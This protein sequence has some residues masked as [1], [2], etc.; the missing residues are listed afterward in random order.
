MSYDSDEV[1]GAETFQSVD[2]NMCRAA[3][4]GSDALP[5]SRVTPRLLCHGGLRLV[6]DLGMTP[7]GPRG[8]SR[9]DGAWS[10]KLAH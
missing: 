4:R 10:G 6:Q 8:A 7:S 5:G 3:M 9:P 2:G 1:A